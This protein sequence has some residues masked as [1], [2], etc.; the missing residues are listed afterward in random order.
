MGE[1]GL[2]TTADIVVNILDTNDNP[3]VFSKEEYK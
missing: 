2:S 1:Q 3:P